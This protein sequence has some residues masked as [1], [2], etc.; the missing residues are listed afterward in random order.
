MSNSVFTCQLWFWTSSQRAQKS[1]K[2]GAAVSTA[3]S[4]TFPLENGN[5]IDTRG[6]TDLGPNDMD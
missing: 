3:E 1:L 5:S 4:E 6:K 2:C